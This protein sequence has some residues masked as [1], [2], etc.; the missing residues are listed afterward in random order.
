MLML[1]AKDSHLFEA[2]HW[3]GM[4]LLLLVTLGKAIILT[5]T[6]FPSSKMM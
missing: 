1:Q 3:A 4:N 2:L 5:E 6:Q